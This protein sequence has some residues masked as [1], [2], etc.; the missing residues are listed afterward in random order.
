MLKSFR[1]TFA[2][3][4]IFLHNDLQ[5][6]K[7]RPHFHS[8][9][10]FSPPLKLDQSLDGF[11][12]N[13]VSVVI[14]VYN[15]SGFIRQCLDSVIRQTYKNLEILIVD[16][17]STDDTA[18]IIQSYSD[19]RIKFIQKK[20]NDGP[21]AT[22]NL[23]INLAEGTYIAFLDSDDV[24]HE[25]KLSIQIGI[26]EQM[27]ALISFTGYA[28]VDEQGNIIRVFRPNLELVDFSSLLK[29]CVIQ[30]STLVINV[31]Q[32][33]KFYCSNFKRRQDYCLILD[34]VKSCG[35][36]LGINKNLAHYRIRR[37]SVSSNKIKNIYWQWHVYR[38][39]LCLNLS[40]SAFFLSCWFFNSGIKNLQR[41][42]YRK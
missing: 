24:W 40:K 17:R 31:K 10:I 11:S 25:D 36:A 1:L 41:W 29:H 27:N 12:K 16:D 9:R 23:A 4:V 14:P 18:N 30:N 22:R 6:G 42:R 13:K 21:G 26:M 7:V 20:T 35:G 33:G 39:H 28:S 37:N 8:F 38:K 5:W 34:S 15:S 3:N 2:I 32:A 19:H